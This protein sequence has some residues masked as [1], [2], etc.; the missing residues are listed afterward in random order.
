MIT[1]TRQLA[2]DERS[3]DQ[4]QVV[5]LRAELAARIDRHTRVDGVHS[6]GIPRLVFGRASRT[7]HPVHG[8]Y[9][10]AF[11]ILA[12]G[13]KRVLLGDEVYVY[14]S[15]RYLVVSQNLPV[16][17][18]VIDATPE[19]PYLSLRLTFE[20]EDI[21]ALTLELRRE[22]RLPGLKPQRGIFT[23]ELTATLLD[24]VLRLIKLLDAPGDIS[25]LAPLA[26]REILYR[27]LTSPDGWKLAQM[28]V[29]EGQG[30]RVTRVID[31]LRLHFHEPLRVEDLAR[32]A[33]MSVS[34]LHSHFKAVTAM[35]PLQF[36]KQLR[37]QEARRVLLNENVDAATAGHRVGYESPSQFSREYSRFFGTPPARDI[38]RLRELQLGGPNA[39]QNA[40]ENADLR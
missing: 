10:P 5:L 29:S 26:M 12:Q 40:G 35:S 4:V 23:G 30:D 34:S 8:L 28:A 7:H 27:L 33:H 9:E 11:C 14:D 2:P 21:V 39:G 38:K 19:T 3:A 20:R 17:S 22:G 16:A 25:T 6:T 37:L 15:S 24:P 32:E 36:Q 1:S 13:S 18:Q 31:W